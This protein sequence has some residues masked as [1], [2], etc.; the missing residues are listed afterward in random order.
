[1]HPPGGNLPKAAPSPAHRAPLPASH[2]L[3]NAHDAHRFAPQP[4]KRRWSAQG[5]SASQCS[6]AA[7]PKSCRNGAGWLPNIV[8]RETIAGSSPRL[9]RF[10]QL[11]PLQRTFGGGPGVRP[12]RLAHIQ[13]DGH[14]LW[15][16]FPAFRFTQREGEVDLFLLRK[17]G[18]EWR[19]PPRPSSPTQEEWRPPRCRLR[20][21]ATFP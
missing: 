1:M 21:P 5:R 12:G 11:G 19:P 14:G 4:R 13:Q 6:V 10:G 3:R 9:L 15:S 17:I 20:S 18:F 2:R 7:P 16:R 8:S